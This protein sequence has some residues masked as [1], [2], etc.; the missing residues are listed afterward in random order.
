GGTYKWYLKQYIEVARK[1]RAT[2]VLVTPVARKYFADKGKIRLNPHHDSEDTGKKNPAA[3][4]AT[5]NNAY[6]EAVKQLAKEDNVILLDGFEFTKALYEKAYADNGNDSQA[7][8]IMSPGDST[9]NNKLGGFALAAEFAKAIKKQI[10]ELAP[11]IIHPAKVIG[12]N[13]DGSL[14]FTVNSSGKI[15]CEN[16]YWKEQIQ[17]S[18]D[19]IK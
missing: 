14:M 12:E 15:E 2:P 9:H 5:K 7:R 4:Y 19:S 8:A 6:V 17:K 13:A 18:M 3:K 1:A 11:S 10:P 16:K